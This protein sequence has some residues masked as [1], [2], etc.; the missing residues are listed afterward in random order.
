MKIC[1]Q[2]LKLSSIVYSKY[3][4]KLITSFYNLVGSTV[5]LLFQTEV[6]PMLQA[7]SK[8]PASVPDV[9]SVQSNKCKQSYK[10]QGM[11]G[12]EAFI[13]QLHGRRKR[14][15]N[16]QSLPPTEFTSK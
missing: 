5:Y 4:K 14:L 6:S 2:L 1:L 9:P 16:S 7:L 10:S 3:Y 15:G 8:R 13:F 11:G 12:P